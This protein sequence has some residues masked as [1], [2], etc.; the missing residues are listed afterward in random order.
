MFRADPKGKYRAVSEKIDRAGLFL[1]KI[2]GLF[3]RRKSRAVNIPDNY[4]SEAQHISTVFNL[5]VAVSNSST[6]LTSYSDIAQA[7]LCVYLRYFCIEKS[8]AR[9]SFTF[10]LNKL[11]INRIK[12]KTHRANFGL[13]RGSKK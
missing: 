7:A 6:P 1:D 4:S 11:P 5:I 2:S 8:F 12:V 9:C 13:L 10:F 3:F